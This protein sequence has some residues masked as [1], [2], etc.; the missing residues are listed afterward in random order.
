MD[1]NI[2]HCCWLQHRQGL[3]DESG[4]TAAD[5]E[6][7]QATSPGLWY[8][9]QPPIL[10]DRYSLLSQPL[11]VDRPNATESLWQLLDLLDSSQIPVSQSELGKLLGKTD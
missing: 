6:N 11:S 7:R 4:I 3:I 2:V 8:E 9:T 1:N 5:S 10:P